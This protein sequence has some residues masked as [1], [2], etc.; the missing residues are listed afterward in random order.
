MS[1]IDA[2]TG[3]KTRLVNLLR[4][5]EGLHDFEI[6]EK[7]ILVLCIHLNSRHWNIA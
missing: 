7:L 6:G 1:L 3:W 4:L 2:L 5:E